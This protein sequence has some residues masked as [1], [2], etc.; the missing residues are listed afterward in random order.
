MVLSVGIKRPMEGRRQLAG[1][2]VCSYGPRCK[3]PHICVGYTR[4]SAISGRPRK[5]TEAYV[6]QTELSL[7]G[8]YHLL[9]SAAALADHATV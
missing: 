8:Q 2:Y 7:Q 1:A 5:Q 6:D 3:F 9:L 4:G